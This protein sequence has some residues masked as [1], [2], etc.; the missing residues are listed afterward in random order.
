VCEEELT[1]VSRKIHD[2]LG[3][4]LTALRVDLGWLVPQLRRNREPVRRRLPRCARLWTIIMDRV[5]RIAARLRPPVLEDLGLVA[6]ID[7][8]SGPATL[9]S[10]ATRY[11]G[12]RCPTRAYSRRAETPLG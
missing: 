9:G 12:P 2:E 11:S 4:V 8:P 10:E 3:H 5:R 6:A 7:A 1:R